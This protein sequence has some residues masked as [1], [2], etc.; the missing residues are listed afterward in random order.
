MVR[1]EALGA[2]KTGV[3]AHHLTDAADIKEIEAEQ[4]RAGRERLVG[5][6]N[7]GLIYVV[8]SLVL[9]FVMW[10]RGQLPPWLHGIVGKP[11]PPLQQ[12]FSTTRD[13]EVFDEQVQAD[14][15]SSS[16]DGASEF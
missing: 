6:R 7:Q 9:M 12:G 15:L 10:R 1:P 4:R 14:I 11:G 5:Q 2:V 8:I 3:L 13:E 16:Q